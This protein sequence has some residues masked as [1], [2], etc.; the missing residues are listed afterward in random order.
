MELHSL[1]LKRFD[2][3]ASGRGPGGAPQDTWVGARRPSADGDGVRRGL[4]NNA[5]AAWLLA[6]LHGQRDCRSRSQEN[7]EPGAP[8]VLIGAQGSERILAGRPPGRELNYEVTCGVSDQGGDRSEPASRIRPA[9]PLGRRGPDGSRRL[10][11][12]RRRG[13][14]ARERVAYVDLARDPRREEEP[15]ARA[16]FR[17]CGR[18][19]CLHALR[20]VREGAAAPTDGWHVDVAG[21]RAQLIETAARPRLHRPTNASLCPW[22]EGEPIDPPGLATPTR[23]SLRWPPNLQGPAP[24]PALRLCAGLGFRLMLKVI[25]PLNHPRRRSGLRVLS[26]RA[27][28]T[29]GRDPLTGMCLM[30]ELALLPVV[31]PGAEVLRSRP[32]PEPPSRRAG[33]H[34]RCTRG[35]ARYLEA[36]YRGSPEISLREVGSSW[37]A[38]SPTS[39]PAAGRLRLAPS[40]SHSASREPPRAPAT[41]TNFHRAPTRSAPRSVVIRAHQPC[42]QRSPAGASPPHLRLDEEPLSRRGGCDA[43]SSPPSRRLTSRCSPWLIC[44]GCRGAGRWSPRLAD[45][46]LDLAGDAQG[47]P[48]LA[49]HGSPRPPISVSSASSPT[50]LA[51]LALDRR[52]GGFSIVF[53]P[54]RSRARSRLLTGA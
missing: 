45:A 24:G 14:A 22:R 35:V 53:A 13:R 41:P 32:E 27:A 34:P 52:W 30:E 4:S 54:R 6:I 47:S 31:L 2:S 8:A 28:G 11:L 25:E 5:E 37:R 51:S 29:R 19:N 44:R 38:A 3:G 20:G 10:G 49:P 42:P 1:T 15:A 43:T 33:P 36:D 21:L 39:S 12:D 48:R 7:R 23:Q 16:S 26:S 9:A 17:R 50:S 18:S 46:D 40:T